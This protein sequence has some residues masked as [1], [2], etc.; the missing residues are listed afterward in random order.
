MARYVVQTYTSK[1]PWVCVHVCILGLHHLGMPFVQRPKPFA[2]G[3]FVCLVSLFD[4][5]I[6]LGFY[7]L[8]TSCQETRNPR[9]IH[10][11]AFQQHGHFEAS[12]LST[13]LHAKTW[14]DHLHCTQ[15]QQRPLRAALRD[16]INKIN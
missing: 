2:S 5:F 14:Q 1:C 15:R 3:I 16:L 4:Y 11:R 10:C 9:R 8:G 13:N 12:L 6:I 7:S